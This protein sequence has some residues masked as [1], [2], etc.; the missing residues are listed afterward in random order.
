[1]GKPVSV[2]TLTTAYETLAGMNPFRDRGYVYDEETGLYYLRSRFYHPSMLRF[3]NADTYIWGH[4][5]YYAG[6]NPV[7][8]ID[9]DGRLFSK[10]KEAADIFNGIKSF[11]DSAGKYTKNVIKAMRMVIMHTLEI[12]R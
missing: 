1:M 3:V 9:A 11:V 6:N 2:R 4:V 10:L 7:N 5:Y 12:E 8:S